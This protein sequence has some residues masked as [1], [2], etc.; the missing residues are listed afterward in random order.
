MGYGARD[1]GTVTFTS[2]G[3][4]NFTFTVM[5]RNLSSTE[6]TLAF[7]YI[8]VSFVGPAPIQRLET[9]S[10]RVQSMTPPPV[11]ISPFQWSGIFSN[12]NA[13]G[14][15]GTYFN[16]TAVGNYVTYTVPGIDAGLYKVRVGIQTKPNKGK[17]QLT[18]NGSNQGQ[19]QDEYSS[20]VT[21]SARD[22]G[23][24]YLASGDQQFK[25]TVTGKN[26]S[27]TGY[28]LAF[29]FIELVPTDR[30]ET[31]SLRVQSIT[32]KP[33]GY[34]SAQWF[35]I[36]NDANASGGTGTYFNAIA[37]GDYIT[38]AVP[39]GRAGTYRVKVGIHMKPNKGMF[40]LAVNG[41]NQGQIQ[42]EYA[43]TIQYSVRDLGPVYLNAGA[44]PFTFT[45]VGKNLASGG[46]TLAFDYI[47]LVPP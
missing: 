33:T 3:I 2:A 8:D 38:Y 19:V 1:L 15:A 46:F 25:L 12:P 23:T 20:T 40:Q 43:S 28:T 44:Q 47:E 24:V 35:G 39:V 4:K 11:G 16:A 9:E 36:F 5:G 18:I 37:T 10:L 45:V 17:F 7:D 34:A 26:A 21:Y 29:D 22:L 31:E 14:L 27:S 32:P 30:A 42:D 41:I 13:S 6:Y